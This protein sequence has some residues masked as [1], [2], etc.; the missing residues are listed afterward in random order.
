M[1]AV[2]VCTTAGAQAT[3]YFKDNNDDRALTST[4][5][6]I[7]ESGVTIN[8]TTLKFELWQHQETGGLNNS[9][10]IAH[11]LYLNGEKIIWQQCSDF[12]PVKF[13]S[14]KVIDLK[15]LEITAATPDG[16]RTKRFEN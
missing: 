15:T 6:L 10:Y 1:L 14:V 13:I 11:D 7:Q 5:V 12:C 8:G 4:P 3:V 16:T 2:F 9:G